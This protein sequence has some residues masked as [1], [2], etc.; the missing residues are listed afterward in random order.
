MP[1]EIKTA[2]DIEKM[3]VVGALAA[4]QLEMIEAFIKP[5]ISTGELNNICHEYTINEQKAI[6]AP[7]NYRGFPKSICTSVNHVVCHGIPSDDKILKHGDIINVDVTLIK[8]EF[9]GDT[10][11]TFYVGK[12]SILAQRLV[13]ICKEALYLGIQ[14]VKPGAFLGD[15]GHA[16]QTH[17]EKNRFSVVR[18]YCGH[19]IGRVFHDEPQVLHYGKRGTGVELKPG[20]VFT[21]EPML[22]AG[23]AAVKLL[24]DEWTVVTKDHKL[25]AQWEHTILVTDT[26]YEI[27]TYREDDTIPRST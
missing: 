15:I 4:K 20:M 25:T 8:D 12:P 1:I 17:A 16:T 27:L 5:G 13:G 24:P 18:E 7:L 11:K 23:K 2:E 3:R 26:G 22:N 9:H 21:I 6:P 10:S 19:G 14:A